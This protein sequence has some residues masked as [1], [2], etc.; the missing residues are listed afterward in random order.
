MR[1]ACGGVTSGG[2]LFVVVRSDD[3]V[4]ELRVVVAMGPH[5]RVTG[6]MAR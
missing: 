2:M 3:V 5:E 6:V 4:G 1:P